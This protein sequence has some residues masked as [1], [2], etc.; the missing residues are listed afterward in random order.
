[1]RGNVGTLYVNEK[2]RTQ[3]WRGHMERFVC[4]E[5]EWDLIVEAYVVEWVK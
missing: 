4:G 3:L 5:N 2:Y 1:M